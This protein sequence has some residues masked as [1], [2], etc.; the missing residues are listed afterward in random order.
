[1]PGSIRVQRETA[2]RCISPH[3]FGTRVKS[4]LRNAALALSLTFAGCGIQDASNSRKQDA[5]IE[6]STKQAPKK[7]P[8]GP[9]R[10]HPLYGKYLNGRPSTINIDQDPKTSR[11][12]VD[13]DKDYGVV[14]ISDPDFYSKAYGNN[15]RRLLVIGSHGVYDI[16]NPTKYTTLGSTSNYTLEDGLNVAIF[17]DVYLIPRIV[18]V[19]TLP[20]LQHSKPLHMFFADSKEMLKLCGADADACVTTYYGHSLVVNGAINM[21]LAGKRIR[22]MQ[23]LSDG[24]AYTHTLYT[25]ADCHI[26][27]LHEL[28]HALVGASVRLP[29][30]VEEVLMRIVQSRVGPQVCAQTLTNCERTFPDKKG[31]QVPCSEVD[32]AVANQESPY[33]AFFTYYAADA[34]NSALLDSCKVAAFS[35]MCKDAVTG[36]LAYIKQLL[37]VLRAQST[38]TQFSFYWFSSIVAC[39]SG[40]QAAALARV[41]SCNPTITSS[42][43]CNSQ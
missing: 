41:N 16:P 3:S 6:F 17:A 12:M 32:F 34:A 24:S 15:H 7:D 22:V 21:D 23:P 30:D 33:T 18:D 20:S 9:Y 19:L 4:W 11:Y 2:Y 39:A 1:L 8:F 13:Q 37:G 29:S 43:Q 36:E 27:D 5:A 31:V 35:Q 28:H 14:S 10:N 25:P 40:N 42:A 26:A 38:S